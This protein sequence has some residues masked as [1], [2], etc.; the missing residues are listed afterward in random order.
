M[1]NKAIEVQLVLTEQQHR[2]VLRFHET[3]EDG[4]GYD[5]PADR[6]KSL[7]RVGLIRSVGFKRYEFTYAGLALVEVAQGIERSQGIP[8]T[9]GQRLNQLANEG[10]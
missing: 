4:Q 8:G 10:E 5:V 6:M 3:T 2:D 7:A 9:S 1:T